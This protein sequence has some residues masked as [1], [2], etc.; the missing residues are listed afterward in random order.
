MAAEQLLRA[1]HGRNERQ[2]YGCDESSHDGHRDLCVV[3]GLAQ[4]VIVGHIQ[5]RD[6]STQATS[7]TIVQ[8]QAALIA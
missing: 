7:T 1:K 8:H 5:D 4:E 6:L 3:V 2:R